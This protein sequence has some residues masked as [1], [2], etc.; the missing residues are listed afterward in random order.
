MKPGNG[1]LEVVSLDESHGIEGATVVVNPQAVDR[2]NPRMLQAPGDLCLKEESRAAV[3]PA[4]V[5]PLDLLQRHLAVY[6]LVLR[7]EDFSQAA[8]GV[9][10]E[11]AVARPGLRLVIDGPLRSGGRGDGR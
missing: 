9:R 5:L 2:H 11:Y 3:F 1:R 10:T 4:G 8:L 6:F 7:D